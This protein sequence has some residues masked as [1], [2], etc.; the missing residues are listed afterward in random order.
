MEWK[1]VRLCDVC[2]ELS[3][4]LHKAPKFIEKGEYIFVNAK[5]CIMVIFLITTLQKRQVMKNI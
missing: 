2:S 4:G 5:T 1:E 3:D